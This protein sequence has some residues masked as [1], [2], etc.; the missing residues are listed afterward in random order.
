MQWFAG[1]PG[2]VLR[3]CVGGQRPAR[4]NYGRIRHALDLFAVNRDV[5]VFA[6]DLR[7][8]RGKPLAVDRERAARGNA[9]FVRHAEYERAQLSHLLLEQPDGVFQPVGAEG[10]TAH[11]FTEVAC[12]VSR[13]LLFG[14]HFV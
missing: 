13:R 11:Q 12:M 1:Q 3:Q 5:R 9:R 2:D 14:F 7:D 8:P 6:Q 10:V 4:N